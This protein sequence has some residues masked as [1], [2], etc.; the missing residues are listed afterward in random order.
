M[1]LLAALG[2]CLFITDADYLEAVDLDGDGHVGP[3]FGGGDCNEGDPNIHPG[4][5]DIPYDGID[6]DCDGANDFDAD[7]DGL[8]APEFG[9]TDCDD[10]DITLGDQVF[11]WYADCDGDGAFSDTLVLSCVVPTD[12]V[13][14]GQAAAAWSP[15]RPERFD[16]DDTSDLVAPGNVDTFYDGL[17]A[18]C[19]GSNDFD[20][21]GDGYVAANVPG[22]VP[23]PDAP[24]IGDCDDENPFIN[25]GVAEVWYDG[26]DQNCDG[27]NDFDRDGDSYVRTGD[28]SQASGTAPRVGDCDDDDFLRNPGAAETF[29]DGVDDD[30]D[31]ANDYDADGDGVVPLAWAAQAGSLAVGDCDDTDPE[32]SPLRPEVWYDG[33]DGDCDGSNDFDADGDGFVVASLPGYTPQELAALA[34]GTAP[35][36]GDCDDREPSAHPGATDAPYDGIDADCDGGND[37]DA[38]GDG[39][40]AAH[41]GLPPA[42]ADCDDTTPSVHPG[43]TDAWYDGVDA[44]CDGRNDYDRDRDGTVE[45]IYSALAGLPGGDCDDGDA[46]R[47]PLN[48]EV[49]YDGIDGDCAGDHDFDRDGDGFV[50]KAF[51]AFAAGLA[52]GDCDDQAPTVFPGATDFWYDGVDSD[53]DGANDY[54][55]DGDGAVWSLYPGTAGGTAPTEGDC[56]DL[57]VAIGPLAPEIWNDGIDSDCDGA[58]D[59]DQDGDG[60]V[61]LGFETQVTPDAPGTGDCNDLDAS[62]SP[63]APEIL[64][65]LVDQDCDGAHLFDVDGD[66]FVAAAFP[67]FAGG[68]APGTGDC[69]DLD[70]AVFPGAV[71]TWYDGVDSD[72]DGLNDF[73]RDGDAAVAAGYD[74]EAAG[75][76]PLVGDC[77]D[78]DPSRGPGAVEI[79]YDGIDQD[80]DGGD[81][82]QDGDGVSYPEDCDDLDPARWIGDA[83]LAL[84]ADV[85]GTLDAA[86]DYAW[87]TLGPGTWPISAP[88][89]VDAFGVTLAGSGTSTVLQGQGNRVLD[90][91]NDLS[92]LEL[93]VADGA[94][95]DGGCVRTSA[96]LDALYVTFRDCTATGRGGAVFVEAG[97]SFA[98]EST[99][100]RDNAAADGAD[101]AAD[102]GIVA[103]DAT[104]FQNGQSARGGALYLVDTRVEPSTDVRFDGSSATADGGGLYAVDGRIEALQWVFQG[105]S[106]GGTGGAV[107]LDGTSGAFTDLDVNAATASPT[108]PSSSIEPQPAIVALRRPGADGG[109]FT[110]ERVDLRDV[111]ASAGIDLLGAVGALRL[112]DVDVRMAPTSQGRAIAMRA[113][114]EGDAAFLD[115]R[116]V[117]AVG[118]S[119]LW[120]HFFPPSLVADVQNVTVVANASFGSPAFDY[121]AVESVLD[122][123][124]IVV[125]NTSGSGAAGI[126]EITFEGQ[127]Y[128]L[129]YTHVLNGGTFQSSQSFPEP[130]PWCFGCSRVNGMAFDGDYRLLSPVNS[131]PGD[132]DVCLPF[133]GA[134]CQA[135]IELTPGYWG[136]PEAPY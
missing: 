103:F 62:V 73:D 105:T 19:D 72:C 94:A 3:A 7:G 15:V 118:W 50:A 115:V 71:E 101:V 61:G 46:A 132:P 99:T 86:C 31:G 26:T 104:V 95:D 128:R 113:F 136:G 43:A 51:N 88:L 53:C 28:A 87:I 97:G 77:D 45:S 127:Q 91:T 98:A 130:D 11:P 6:S 68:T 129:R 119:G 59:Y 69:D 32:R 37:W 34:G 63:G 12:L 80:C 120:I 92:L 18:D 65:D 74:A 107:F 93:I 67:D 29:Y 44:N 114:D 9:G 79:W 123:T 24:H 122:M 111:A 8:T 78:D 54:D 81:G 57:I 70:P 27:R 55:Q 109:T 83:V 106:A 112:H 117:L 2:G 82:D 48:D 1:L 41:P 66:G 58:N 89:T 13:C 76:A 90:L 10:T 121:Q 5:P 33:R 134:P 125:A 49:W 84:P 126:N 40:E 108:W 100:F 14:D 21:D 30:C 133:S 60:Y 17:D 124:N 85:Q 47:S 16:C 75:S 64:Y 36:S 39:F 20:R 25:P 42:L 102:G 38:D 4:A 135:G 131:L 52:P 56:D 22:A 110:L 116:N 35:A 23:S 96:G